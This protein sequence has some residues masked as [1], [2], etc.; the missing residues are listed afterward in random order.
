MITTAPTPLLVTFLKKPIIPAGTTLPN[1]VVN[2]IVAAKNKKKNL[3]PCS[4]V[5]NIPGAAPAVSG[6]FGAVG[7][8]VEDTLIA[9]GY[10]VN[11]GKGI[12]LPPYNIE[13]KT[14][15]LQTRSAHTL[16][17][18]T[19]LN[20]FL[21]PWDFSPIKPKCQLHYQVTWDAEYMIVKEDRIVDL[22]S[23]TRQQQ[24]KTA[25]ENAR[26]ELIAYYST[27]GVSEVLSNTNTTG[28][29]Y[30][31]TSAN[32]MPK[33]NNFSTLVYQFRARDGLMDA[34]EMVGRRNVYD[35][36]FS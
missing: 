31:E 29:L 21:N 22:R 17:T 13:I 25:Y 3:N 7:K 5:F 18:A 4:G 23:V 6:N 10:P 15:Q 19:L 32:E 27:P 8:W 16:G 9:M 35:E 2:S 26:D 1:W 34:W 20:I 36:L 14:R 11:R 33:D 12:D 30:F 24:F 28:G